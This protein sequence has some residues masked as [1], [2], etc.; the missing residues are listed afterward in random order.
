[1]AHYRTSLFDEGLPLEDCFR[2]VQVLFYDEGTNT[3]STTSLEYLDELLL[4][5]Q[6]QTNRSS[7]VVKSIASF[8]RD[9]AT[10]HPNACHYLLIHL[11][12]LP[13]PIPFMD[14]MASMFCVASPSLVTEAVK[15]LKLLP[16]RDST[17]L[18]PVIAVMADLPLSPD[19]LSELYELAEGAIDRVEES[20]LPAL[21]R[22]LL[23]SLCPQKAEKTLL[24]IRNEVSRAPLYFNV[25][26]CVIFK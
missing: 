6:Y 17:L 22:T 3:E 2:R 5:L 7:A 19:L 14:V 8:V 23:K 11:V 25:L 20:E 21:F 18:L 1:M 10:Y 9:V 24:K 26:I 15:Q 12:S 16:E 13:D 4:M